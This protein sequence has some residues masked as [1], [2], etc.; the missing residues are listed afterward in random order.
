[1]RN[2]LI[3][4]GIIIIPLLI[5]SNVLAKNPFLKDCKM[6]G[7]T[8]LTTSQC[9]FYLEAEGAVFDMEADNGFINGLGTMKFP[10]GSFYRGGFV[11]AY[12]YGY[13][14]YDLPEFN[15]AS[16]GDYNA[17]GLIK[18]ITILEGDVLVSEF[19]PAKAEFGTIHGLNSNVYIG[20]LKELKYHGE[21]IIYRIRE[22]DNRSE[23]KGDYSFGIWEEGKLVVNYREDIETCEFDDNDRIIN[24]FCYLRLLY[25]EVKIHGVYENDELKFGFQEFIAEGL[26]GLVMGYFLNDELHGYGYTSENAENTEY[27]IGE[28]QNGLRHG[29]G[30]N[31]STASSYYGEY[32][33]GKR[34]GFGYEVDEEKQALGIWRNDK[35]NGYFEIDYDSGK[36]IASQF[37]D[38]MQHGLGY[39]QDLGKSYYGEFKNNKFDGYGVIY[40]GENITQGLFKDNELQEELIFCKS[41]LGTHSTSPKDKK[42]SFGQSQF[43]FREFIYAKNNGLGE[44]WIEEYNKK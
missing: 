13:G 9:N 18:G 8:F 14:K 38:N 24:E 15:Q 16:I 34:D 2:I 36:F 23:K 26:E 31:V 35:R 30:N 39:I 33:L 11:D 12:F 28:Y 37:K 5:S 7:K 6:S 43:T 17:E 27:Y 22:D 10:E 44:R 19:E 25:D 20:G 4:F 3:N 1:M 41:L 32:K 21:G 40:E 42:C 29:Y